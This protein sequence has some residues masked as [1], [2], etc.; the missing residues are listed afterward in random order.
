MWEPATNEIDTLSQ[1]DAIPCYNDAAVTGADLS[2]TS[3]LWQAV[4]G[5]GALVAP[6]T[7]GT[8][9][10]NASNADGSGVAILDN[11]VVN[12]SDGTTYTVGNFESTAVDGVNVLAAPDRLKQLGIFPSDTNLGGDIFY[13]RNLGERVPLR[14]GRWDDGGS[15]RSEERRVGKECSSRWSPYH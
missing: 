13:C 15:A 12:Q 1:H 8:M 6:G 3:A 5:T 14:G 4:D 2:A 9:K 7:A 10:F 11:V